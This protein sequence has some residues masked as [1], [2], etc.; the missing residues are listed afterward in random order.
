MLFGPTLAAA[1]A[2]A[3]PAVPSGSFAYTATYQGTPSGKSSL[4]V[5]RTGD[6]TTTISERAEGNVNGLDIAGTA[7]LTVGADL[8]PTVYD[9]SYESGALK[10]V[11]TVSVTPSAAT[12]VGTNSNGQAIT[13]PLSNG[14]QH[15]VVIEPGLMAGLFAL[16]AQM[17]AWN[18]APILAIAPS[19]ARAQP[20]ALDPGAKPQRPGGVPAADAA[21]SFGGPLA[22]TIWYDPAT[23]VPDEVVVPSQDAIVTR[24]R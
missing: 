20:F 5:S 3:V 11:V 12:I 24:V 13:F 14:A 1:L 18:G 7:T 6:Q 16:P 23:L 9:G 10:T 21:L 19:A 2:A 15:F 4:T 17:Q 8:V 22:F